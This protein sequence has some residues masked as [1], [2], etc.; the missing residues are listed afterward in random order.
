[1]YESY[2]QLQGKP[3]ATGFDAKTYYPAESHQGALLKL[4]YAIENRRGAALLVGPSGTGKTVLVRL[5]AEQLPEN[6]KPLVHLVF[7]QMPT[8]DLLSYLAGELGAGTNKRSPS[9]AES[10]VDQSV[11]RIQ[12]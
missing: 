10:S 12:E 3:F 8:T 4:R 2:W 5:L 11:R 6:C 9:P 1:M 7:P